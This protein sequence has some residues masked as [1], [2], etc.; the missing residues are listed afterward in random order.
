MRL[1]LHFG[2]RLPLMLGAQ[3]SGNGGTP[4]VSYENTGIDTT[5]SIPANE[6]VLIGTLILG[7]SN[8]LLVLV[9]SAKKLP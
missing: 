5:V 3:S 1:R 7:P 8:D 6:P 2:A 9:I 4:V